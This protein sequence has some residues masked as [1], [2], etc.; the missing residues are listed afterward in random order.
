MK[1]QRPMKLSPRLRDECWMNTTTMG[2]QN[3]ARSS[4]RW[5]AEAL[6]S[7]HQTQTLNYLKLFFAVLLRVVGGGEARDNLFNTDSS[8]ENLINFVC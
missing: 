1:T 7:R 8:L 4:W 5:H 6:D 3:W 2:W